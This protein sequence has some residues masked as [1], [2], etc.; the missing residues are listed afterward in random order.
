MK[1]NLLWRKSAS[2]RRGPVRCLVAAA[3]LNLIIPFTAWA[4]AILIDS[5]LHEA[6]VV[7]ERT[8]AV[9]L[10]FDTRIDQLR[11]KLILE[12][13]SHRSTPV[14]VED[15]SMLRSKLLA[16]ISDLKPGSYKL[17]WQVLAVNGH[18]TRGVISFSVR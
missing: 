14:A 13:P 11:S 1:R 18:I 6:A 17:R 5:T 16:R 2:R 15:D 12:G 8:F 9:E 7:S 10:S 4:R 3:A